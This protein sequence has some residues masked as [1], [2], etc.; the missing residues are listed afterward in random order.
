[1][2]LTLI[3]DLCFSSTKKDAWSMSVGDEYFRT[4]QHFNLNFNAQ[5]RKTSKFSASFK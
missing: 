1:M 3:T 2:S 4:K 5:R